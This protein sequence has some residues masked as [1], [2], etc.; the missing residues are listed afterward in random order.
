MFLET[1]ASKLHGVDLDPHAC[2]LARMAVQR[3]VLTLSP[4]KSTSRPLCGNVVHADFLID[5]AVDAFGS[6]K[7][8]GFDFI[9]GNPPVRV[10]HTDQ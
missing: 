9:V 1:V 7:S 10:C 2:V 4:G 6:V 8:G 5:P 3:A